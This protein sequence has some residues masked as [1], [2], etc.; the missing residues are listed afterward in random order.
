MIWRASSGL[1]KRRH[2]LLSLPD[3]LNMHSPAPKIPLREKILLVDDVPANLGVLSR[4]LEAENY[5]VL[6]APN[7]STAL[8]LAAKA[9]PSLILLDV[10]MPGWD[11]V[12]TCRQL[13]ALQETRDIPVIFITARNET[14]DIVT[15][16]RAGGVDYIIKPFQAEEVVTRVATHL[17]ISRLNRQLAEK[18]RT[19]EARTSEL[20]AEM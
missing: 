20:T 12:E 2:S 19:L 3:S 13:K 15:G 4:T 14:N 1:L 11:G 10:L 5:E 6:V 16:F 18:N 8:K 17:T 9:Q 7:G